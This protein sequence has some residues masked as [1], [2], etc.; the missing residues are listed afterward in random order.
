MQLGQME[1]GMSVK[2]VILWAWRHR[3]ATVLGSSALTLAGLEVTAVTDLGLT[4]PVVAGLFA[5]ALSASPV[6]RLHARSLRERL[7]LRDR[8]VETRRMLRAVTALPDATVNRT[9]RA[10]LYETVIGAWA[11]TLPGSAIAEVD[12]QAGDAQPKEQSAA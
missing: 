5:A 12:E 10:K 6:A 8:S 4:P 3:A 2:T 7:L 9:A 1:V 11:E